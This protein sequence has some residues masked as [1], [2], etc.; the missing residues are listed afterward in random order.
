MGE[1]NAIDCF[2]LTSI[3]RACFGQDLHIGTPWEILEEIIKEGM[4][5]W[6]DG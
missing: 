2:M 6:M 3:W 1:T 5:G 4:D